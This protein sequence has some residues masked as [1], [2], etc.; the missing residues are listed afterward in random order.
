MALPYLQLLNMAQNYQMPPDQ[1]LTGALKIGL[2]LQ[3]FN[4]LGS[5]SPDATKTK[6]LRCP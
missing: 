6:D 2:A 4:I 3:L 5:K 1:S